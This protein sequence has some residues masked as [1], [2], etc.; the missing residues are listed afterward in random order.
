MKQWKW[1]LIIIIV[2]ALLIMFGGKLMGKSDAEM[3]KNPEVVLKTSFGDIT[4]ELFIGKAPKTVENFLELAEGGFY[5]GTRF[6]RV[7]P[8]FMIQSG[9]PKS[10]D[11]SLMPEW[12]TG[13]PGYQ[14]K[15]EIN[16][17]KLER[18]IL[19]MANSGPDTNGSQFFIVTAPETPWLDGKHTAFGRVKSGLD[20]VLEIEKVKTEGQNRPA[21]PVTIEK[22]TVMKN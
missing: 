8:N 17:V 6:H 11:D 1:L 15:Y 2:A 22:V 12:G 13:G 14:F 19:A 9:D 16:D 20:V 4:L 3:G 7:I 10:K 18:V 21:E 5:D